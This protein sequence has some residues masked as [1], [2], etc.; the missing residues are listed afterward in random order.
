[1]TKRPLVESTI[2]TE[3]GDVLDD[4]AF[5]DVSGVDRDMTYV[6]GFS[7]M[8][9]A[10]DIELAEVAQGR[11]LARDA[12]LAPLPVNMRWVR[13]TTPNGAPDARKE[14]G[15]ANLGYRIATKD[16]IGKNPWLKEM[17]PGAVVTADGAIQKGDTVL[18]LTDNKTAARNA[19]RKIA[20]TARMVND[21]AA[22]SGGLL[23]VA[24]NKPGAE[25]YAKQEA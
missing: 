10:R 19:A 11:K 2:R 24:R 23:D 14:L 16:M 20:Q 13:R 25:P 22:A 7:E 8:R 4:A 18:M 6:P 3:F 5:H 21:T 15:S 9:R 1:M 17:P 12:K